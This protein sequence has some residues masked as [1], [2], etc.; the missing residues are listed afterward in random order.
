MRGGQEKAGKESVKADREMELAFWKAIEKSETAAN[1]QAYLDQFPKGTFAPLAKSR[2]A[3]LSKPAPAP[4]AAGAA[5]E[6]RWKSEV[7]VNRFDKNERYRLHFEFEVIGAKLLGQITRR[8]TKDSKRRYPAT[9]RAIEDGRI[10]DGVVSF[11][12]SFKVML[13]SA[14]ER[15]ARDFTGA[16]KGGRLR[17]FVQDTLGNPPLKFT[18][19]RAPEPRR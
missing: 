15:H 10:E 17:F 19:E 13:G 7:L 3:A 2:L 14:T 6:G 9:T 11:K 12:E 1:F 18:A 5:I 8:S 16:A 4:K